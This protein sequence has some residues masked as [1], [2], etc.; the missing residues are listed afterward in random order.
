MGEGLAAVGTV[1]NRSSAREFRMLFVVGTTTIWRNG[2]RC[3]Q[4]VLNRNAGWAGRYRRDRRDRSLG[5]LARGNI[6][7]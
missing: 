4:G 3:R 7:R 1:A 6:S 5:R 2:T